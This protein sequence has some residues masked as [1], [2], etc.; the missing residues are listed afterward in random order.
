[1]S[2]RSSQYNKFKILT[3]NRKTLTS[4]GSLY[5]AVLFHIVELRTKLCKK[6]ML[7][8]SI[9]YYFITEIIKKRKSVF[10]TIEN[11]INSMIKIVNLI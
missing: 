2:H 11:N 7:L 4:S 6:T 1:M 5:A 3:E 10:P 8:Y 9:V